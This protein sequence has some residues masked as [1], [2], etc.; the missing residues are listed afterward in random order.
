MRGLAALFGENCEVVL[1]DHKD[2][3]YEHTIVAIE[4]GHVTGRTIGDCGTNLGL[5]V[6]RGTGD[7]RDRYNYATQTKDGRVLRSS[8]VYIHDDAGEVVG[9]LCVNIDITDMMAA[10]H[11]IGKLCQNPFRNGKNGGGVEKVQEVFAHD[12]SE[13]T[14]ALIQQAQQVIDKPVSKMTKEDKMAVLRFLDNHGAFLIK[15]AGEKIAA[16]L[17]ISKFTMY[18]YLDVIRANTTV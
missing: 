12:V 16:F 9:S 15:K 18:S 8:T 7:G 4:N 17:D 2:Q 5:E 11:V 3:P 6:L 10:E 14:D 13:L 1:H